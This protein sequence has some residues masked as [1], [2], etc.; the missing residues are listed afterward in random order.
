MK[1][2]KIKEKNKEIRWLIKQS[3]QILPYLL[4]FVF[5]SIAVSLCGV[6]FALASRSVIDTAVSSD[7][8]GLLYKCLIML[9]VILLQLSVQALYSILNVK[10]SIKMEFDLKTSLYKTILKKDWLQISKYHSGDLMTRMTSDIGV[11]TGGIT[12]I[13]PTVIAMITQ[14]IAAFSVLLTFDPT[15]AVIALILGPF[16]VLIGMLYSRRIKKLHILCQES[17]AKARSFIQEALQNLLLIKTFTSENNSIDNFGKALTENYRLQI[18]K[19]YFGVFSGSGLSFGFWLG[20]LF[21]IAWGSFRLSTG[22]ITFGTLTAFLQLVG[23]VQS[24]FH[25][26]ARIFPKIYSTIASA[27]RILAIEEMP[28]ESESRPVRPAAGMRCHRL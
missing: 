27:G 5:L 6:V 3:K 1:F 21:A 18:K 20:Y 13:V 10:A 14:I 22:F 25:G 2:V 9:A 24:P 23:Q 16:V 19:N 8:S 15:F 12:D 7:K 28:D 11:I 17:D 26:M 4:L